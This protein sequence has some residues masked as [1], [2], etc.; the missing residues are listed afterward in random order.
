MNILFYIGIF[1]FAVGAW[2]AFMRGTHSEVISGISLILGVIFVFIGN[3][4]AGLFFIYLFISWF[5]LMQIF[6]FSTYHEYFWKA[7]P[8]LI[9]YAALVAFLLKQFNFE[10][11]FLWYLALSALFLFINH[12]K[13]L[14]SKEA[15]DMPA[16]LD[17][18]VLDSLPE[19]EDKK[20]VE[21]EL[22]LAF[23]R[24]IKYHLLSSVV[25]VVSFVLAFYYFAGSASLP[26][27]QIPHMDIIIFIIILA[28]IFYYVVMVKNGG[29]SFWKKA[30]KKPDFFYEYLLKD[31]AWVIDDGISKIDKDKFDG[32][33]LL[34]VPSINK[35]IK[36]YGE[37]GRYEDS[38]KRMEKEL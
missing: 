22:L 20:H 29:L 16:H 33:F 30:T 8:L 6:R 11:F 31:N 35:T 26:S 13:Q 37:V 12:R 23:S 38:Q 10:N 34:Y 21:K 18:G 25:F 3:W 1:L 28:T 7:S 15:V 9:G 32:P 14:K 17:K 19:G 36:F 4:H 24:M 5:L 27:L 2:L